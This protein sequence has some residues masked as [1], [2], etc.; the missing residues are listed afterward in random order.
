MRTRPQQQRT[1]PTES[2]RRIHQ[3]VIPVY[4]FGVMGIT[5]NGRHL[6]AL[7][8][9]DLLELRRTV[10]GKSHTDAFTLVQ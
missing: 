8:P 9:H 10:V 2:D 7:K 3:Q 1:R 6:M 4:D 5:K